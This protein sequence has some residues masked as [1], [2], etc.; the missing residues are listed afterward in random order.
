MLEMATARRPIQ[1]G[2]YIV[3][4]VK[5]KIGRTR[6]LYNLT[7]IM[8]PVL[9]SSETML[10]GFE[11]FVDLALKCVEDVRANRPTMGEVVKEIENIVLLAGMN[12][13]ADSASVSQSYEGASG[14]TFGDLYA[15]YALSR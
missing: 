15:N 2:T 5:E 14:D 1:Q 13:N 8:D 9:L 3:K 11:K 7:E 4:V 10:V 6:H 12:P